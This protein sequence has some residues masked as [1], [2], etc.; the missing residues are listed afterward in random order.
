MDCKP[1]PVKSRSRG[2]G[3]RNGGES[4]LWAMKW[5]YLVI[6]MSVLL[7]WS[8]GD[9]PAEGP[10]L[11]SDPDPNSPAAM[12]RIPTDPQGRPDTSKLAAI[13]F[14]ETVHFFGQVKEG[15]V[16]EH[17]FRFTNTGPVALIIYD[18]RSTCGCTVPEFPKEPIPPGE[19]SQMLVRFNTQN[20]TGQQVK[21]VTVQANTLPAETKLSLSGEVL[22][23]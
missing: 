1:G 8:C 19:S 11:E 13:R 12:V 21:T 17:T 22:P 7:L 3:K 9:T 16:V 14:E 4:Y 20:K 18:A 15:E 10:L 2:S 5:V 23:Q 6:G